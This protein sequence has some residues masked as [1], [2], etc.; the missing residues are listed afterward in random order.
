MPVKGESVVDLTARRKAIISALLLA[1]VVLAVFFPVLRNDFVNYDDTQ[2][3]I[4][5]PA[6]RSLSAQNIKN[7]FSSFFMGHYD[8]LTILFHAGEYRLFKLDAGGYHFCSLLLHLFN[9]LLVFRLF[10]LVS[11]RLSSAFFISMIFAVHPLQ[12][13]TVAWASETKNV[14]YAFFYLAALI[15]YLSYLRKGR[16]MK[17]IYLALACFLFSLLA[18]SM[19]VTLP[20]VLILIDYLS[21]RRMDRRAICEKIPFF[22]LSL[23]FACVALYGGYLSGTVRQEAAFNFLHKV[24]TLNYALDFYVLKFFAPFKL[25]VFYY[26]PGISD[27]PAGAAIWLVCSFLIILFLAGIA[28]MRICPA[29]KLI[30]GCLF[31]LATLLPV[32]QLVPVGGMLVANHFAYIPLL[33]I[34]YV[35]AEIIRGILDRMKPGSLLSKGLPVLLFVVIICILSVMTRNRC[36]VWKD[37]ASLWSSVIEEYPD[38][39]RAYNSR[40]TVFLKRGQYNPALADFQQAVRL[41]FATRRTYNKQEYFSMDLLYATVNLANTYRA[42]GDIDQAIKALEKAIK[43]NPSSEIAYFNLANIYSAMGDREQA[44]ALYK[45]AIGIYPGYAAAYNNL[46]VLYAAAGADDQAIS[47]FAKAI[48]IDPAF[49]PAYPR[50]DT[51]YKKRQKQDKLLA[52]YE[53]AI[54]NDIDFFEAYFYMGNLF[55]D[56]G[57]E[58]QAVELY[59]KAS[60]IDPQSV[61]AHVNLGKSYCIIGRDK[62]ALV[63]LNKALKLDPG[64]GIIHNNLAIVYYYKKKYHLAIKHCDQAIKLGYKVEPEFLARLAVYR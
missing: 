45:K 10:Y 13:D 20:L 51:Y 7:I 27:S 33:G 35:C 11:G 39:A 57:N 2:N 42:M 1:G 23:F 32:L 6:I 49:L 29:R 28:A 8:P 4:E 55:S 54:S 3:V 61:D 62:E 43:L 48:E 15:F 30:F 22:I 41:G 9:C 40:G 63:A 50:L 24:F 19:A 58:R 37:G 16:K 46:G 53:K 21:N 52:L 18:K 64:L 12:A 25:S 17:Y 31:F 47:M 56:N 26:Y 14:L 36:R 60:I 59:R 34:A 38:N 5:N 44:I